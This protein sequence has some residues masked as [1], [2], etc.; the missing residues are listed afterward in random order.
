MT[1]TEMLIELIERS[2]LKKSYIA[3]K[4]GFSRT[5]FSKKI[6]NIVP[7]N[8]YEIERLCEILKISDL[9]TKEA[10]FFA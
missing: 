2:G 1:N 8:Q 7:F 4:V 9:K 6:K 5:T 3:D 10:V